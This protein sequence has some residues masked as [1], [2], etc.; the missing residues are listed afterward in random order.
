MTITLTNTEYLAQDSPYAKTTLR[1]LY[2]RYGEFI[3]DGLQPSPEA[4]NGYKIRY[5]GTIDNATIRLDY[6]NRYKDEK[7]F[8]ELNGSSYR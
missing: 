2:Y 6:E 7:I 4:L 5:I 1:L 8:A 3:M